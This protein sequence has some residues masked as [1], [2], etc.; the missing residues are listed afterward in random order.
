MARI[1]LWPKQQNGGGSDDWTE[2]EEKTGRLLNDEITKRLD[3]QRQSG[4]AVDTKAGI[5][6]AAALAG[7]QFVVAQKHFNAPLLIATLIMLA[8]T[9]VLA[10]GAIK[11][12]QFIEVPE[13]LPLYF[14]HKDSLSAPALFDLAITKAEAFESNRQV[15]KK[16]ARLQ[17]WSLWTLAAGAVLAAAARV[18]GS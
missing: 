15:Y 10:Y 5:V 11:A 2:D 18:V 6:A 4:A 14:L 9:A 7:T 3:I 12:R 17:Q 13:P 16:K 8:A 1:R